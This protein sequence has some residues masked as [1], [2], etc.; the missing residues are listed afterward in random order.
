MYVTDDIVFSRDIDVCDFDSVTE[1]TAQ[2]LS[3]FF[4]IFIFSLYSIASDVAVGVKV[5]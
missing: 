4:N 1:Q 5:R 3:E 2:N